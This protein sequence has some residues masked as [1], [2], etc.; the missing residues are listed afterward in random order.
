MAA[1]IIQQVKRVYKVEGVRGVWKRGLRKIRLALLRAT[2]PRGLI[3]R[4][5]GESLM[6][7]DLYD[8]GISIELLETR[9]HEPEVTK[10]LSEELEEGMNVI[11]I[12]ANI[13]Y[14]VLLEAKRVGPEGKVYAIEPVPRT[15]DTLTL[16]IQVNGLSN[17]ECFPVAIAEQTGFVEM[18][19]TVS[20]NWSHVVSG[21]VERMKTEGFRKFFAGAVERRIKV[22]A[23][24]LDEFVE[25]AGVERV[26]FIRMDIEGYEVKVVDGMWRILSDP[27]NRPLKLCWELHVGMFENPEPLF[28]P[29]LKRLFDLGFLPGWVRTFEGG[30]LR[31]LSPEEFL[32]VILSRPFRLYHILLVKE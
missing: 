16:N 18:N 22:P 6:W 4:K 17:V 2:H 30:V 3:L 7:L 25:R 10:L 31:D 14:Y 20:S 26:N 5:V 1:S 9:A 23:L 28:A 29:L 32:R 8:R 15:F 13:G 24:T 21:D 27:R 11:D 19:V 12:G